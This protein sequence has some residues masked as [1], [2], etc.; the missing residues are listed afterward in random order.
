M[1]LILVLRR[2][3][4]KDHEFQVSFETPSQ[5]RNNKMVAMGSPLWENSS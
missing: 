3:R 2:L 5:N 1:P 4:Q